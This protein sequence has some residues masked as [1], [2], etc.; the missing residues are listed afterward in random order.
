MNKI[1]Q[2]LYKTQNTLQDKMGNSGF[3]RVF[4]SHRLYALLYSTF[5]FLYEIRTVRDLVVAVHP[6]FIAWGCLLIAYDLLVAGIWKDLPYKWLLAAFA[7]SVLITAFF[8]APHV[9]FSSAM[10]SWVLTVLPF[11]VFYPLFFVSKNRWKDVVLCSLGFLGVTFAASFVGLALFMMRFAGH[12]TLLGV[13]MPV[14]LQN[15][16][17]A[18]GSNAIILLGIYYD[19]N[20]AATFV[21][22]SALLSAAIL[23]MCRTRK[24]DKGRKVLTVFTIVNIVAQA[25]YFPLANSRGAFLTLFA[26]AG[27]VLFLF[28]MVAFRTKMK[29]AVR[30]VVSLLLPAVFLAVLYAGLMGIR[31]GLDHVSFSISERRAAQVTQQTPADG[32][33]QQVQTPADGTGQQAQTPADKS[34]DTKQDSFKKVNDSFGAGRLDIWRDALELYTHNPVIGIGPAHNDLYAQMY[35]MQSIIARGK[36]LHNSYMDLL[37]D[38]GAVGFLLMMTF[39]VS[40]AV[41]VVRYYLRGPMAE[42]TVM[43]SF[44]MMIVAL[45]LASAFLLS[46]L[47]ISTTA[48]EYLFLFALSYLVSAC[49]LPAGGGRRVSGA[50]ENRA[51]LPRKEDKTISTDKIRDIGEHHEQSK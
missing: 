10:K 13:S 41:G 28:F 12:F 2:T 48:M 50:G 46:C 6:V 24:V 17:N 42:K 14:G 44:M 30:V 19:S 43:L 1:G 9:G 16:L 39:L 35:G 18:D 31:T 15:Y 7:L 26:S 47:F 4:F 21:A 34:D 51:R 23:W 36:A 8:T 29:A 32:T 40:A 11:G 25:C 33:G 3:C 22:A 45:P 20:H 27:I 38:Y 37:V 5:L 49:G